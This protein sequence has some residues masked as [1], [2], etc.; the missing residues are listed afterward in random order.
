M[1][2]ERERAYWRKYLS[3]PKGKLARKKY[4]QTEKCKAI[5]K[6]YHQTE[7]WKAVRKKYKKS[8]KGIISRKKYEA[9]EKGRAYQ[10]RKALKRW[11]GD[12]WQAAIALRKLQNEIKLNT[13]R[14]T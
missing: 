1:A 11:W 12:F 3:S 2:T 9:S 4:Q 14:K 7:K 13:R 5:V 6:R 8:A 10:Q